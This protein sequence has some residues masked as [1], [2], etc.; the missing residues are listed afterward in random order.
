MM[1]W[2]TPVRKYRETEGTKDG[3]NR[4]H[5]AA[6]AYVAYQTAYFKTYY[7]IEFMAA[8]MT[9]FADDQDKVRNYVSNARQMGINVLPPDMNLSQKG[10]SI[11]GDNLRFGLASIK[12][13]GE[14]VIHYIL[15]NRPFTSLEYLIETT[16]KRNLNRKALEVLSL[17]GALDRFWKQK[18]PEAT[19]INRME[20]LQEALRLRGDKIDLTE[21][22]ESFNYRTLLD[23]EKEYLGMHI[24]GHPLDGICEPL[25]WNTI[26]F[27]EKFETAGI[28]TSFKEIKTKKGEPMAFINV[29]TTGGN[30]RVVIFP[31][32]YQKLDVPLKNGLIVKM[33]IY[34]K[35]DAVRDEISYIAERIQIPKRINKE[36]LER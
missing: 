24:S 16:P 33:K 7:P 1:V 34:K 21:Q 8:L 27:F 13:L 2:S 25:N 36:V 11:E 4:S 5:A 23:K 28:I 17:S 6:Y 26:G 10:F 29:D 15:E 14:A 20:I 18:N 12:G 22:V 3:F 35:Y 32:A 30:E 19:F 31:D 9:V